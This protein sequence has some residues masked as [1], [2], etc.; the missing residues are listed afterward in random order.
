MPARLL[1][2]ALSNLGQPGES[3]DQLSLFGEV[4]ESV[5]DRQLSS[6]VDTINA[7][8]GRDHIIR[9]NTVDPQQ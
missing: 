7:R 2:V 1:G 8:F 4:D 6:A 9:G 3:L 5:R